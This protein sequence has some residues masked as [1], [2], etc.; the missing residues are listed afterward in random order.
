VVILVA[1]SLVYVS[2]KKQKCVTKSPT[3]AELVALTDNIGLVELVHE[4]LEFVTM[5]SIS[6]PIIC[7]DATSVISHIAKSGGIKWTNH[8]RARMHLEK[9]AYDNKCIQVSHKDTKEMEADGLTKIFDPGEHTCFAK[10]IQ[11]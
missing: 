7:Q 5:K 4:F 2:S 1:G 3:E 10:F 11:G 8:L 6:T 9:E